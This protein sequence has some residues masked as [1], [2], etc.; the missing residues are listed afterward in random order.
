M[1][2]MNQNMIKGKIKYCPMRSSDTNLI[3]KNP[4]IV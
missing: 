1:D 2:T 4:E 3:T